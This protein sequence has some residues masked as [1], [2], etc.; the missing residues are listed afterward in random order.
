MGMLFGAQELTSI[1]RNGEFYVSPQ[2][3]TKMGLLL[4]K[5][6][7]QLS[8]SEPEHKQ[9]LK[10]FKQVDGKKLYTATVD[11]LFISNISSRRAEANGQRM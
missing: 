9:L 6:A 7:E 11:N 8:V 3:M 5:N 4:P 2:N 10:A 1:S